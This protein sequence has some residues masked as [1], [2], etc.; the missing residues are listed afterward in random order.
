VSAEYLRVTGPVDEPTAAALHQV[1]VDVVAG[2]GAIGWPEPPSR[3]AFDRWLNDVI[4][5]VMAAQAEAMLCLDTQAG[6]VGFG[7]W[8]RYPRP[9]LRH[10][11]DMEKVFVAPTAQRSGVG[12]QLTSRLIDVARAAGVETLT[13]DVRGDNL[14]AV[15]LYENFGFT[16]YGRLPQFVAFGPRRYDQIFMSLPLNPAPSAA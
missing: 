10:N 16:E 6:V 12:R 13:L 5:A 14:G 2:G 9:T 4:G 8:R 7:Y 15:R 3:P 11:A 1:V